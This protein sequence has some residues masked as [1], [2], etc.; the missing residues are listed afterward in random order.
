MKYKVAYTLEGENF[1]T[2]HMRYFDALNQSTALNMFEATME[3]THETEGSK[4]KGLYV[5][6]SEKPGRYTW[7]ELKCDEKEIRVSYGI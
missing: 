7:E 5:N 4:I 1:K 3:M 2:T 6:V